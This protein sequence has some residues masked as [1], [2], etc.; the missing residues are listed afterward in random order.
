[1]SDSATRNAADEEWEKLLRQWR[2]QQN[3]QPKPFF[4]SRVRTRL[5]AQD[6]MEHQ[7][8]HSWLRWPSYAVMLIIVLLLSGD[9]ALPRSEEAASH[10]QLYSPAD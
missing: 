3:A 4:Y 2:D 8:L 5:V 10:P 9:G 1:M 7:L 6:A